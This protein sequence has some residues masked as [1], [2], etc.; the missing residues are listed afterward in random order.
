VAAPELDTRSD[1]HAVEPEAIKPFLKA[2]QPHSLHSEIMTHR[3]KISTCA[4]R[5]VSTDKG[6]D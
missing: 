5:G 4:G 1:G 2:C 6:A 3:G